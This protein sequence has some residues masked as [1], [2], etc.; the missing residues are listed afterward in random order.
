MLRHKRHLAGVMRPY[1]KKGRDATMAYAH[2]TNLYR[3]TRILELRHVFALEKIHGTSAHIR[4]RPG[5]H[6]DGARGS[7]TSFFSG[8]EKHSRFVEL[9]DEDDLIPKLNTMGQTDIVVYGEAYGGKQQ[10][11][12]ATYGPDLRFVVFEVKV[13]YGWLS[14]TQ[15]ETCA[16]AL[17][18]EFV[19]YEL[20][21]TDMDTI[22]AHRD[23]SS[24]QAQRNGMGTGHKKEGI[25][26]RPPFEITLSDGSRL[27]AKH[28]RDDFRETK[29]LRVV[30]VEPAVLTNAL[31][32]AEEW[33]T[34]MRF[35]HVMGKLPAAVDM[36]HTAA[37]MRAMLEDV[38]REGKGEI[39][40][41]KAVKKAIGHATLKLWKRYMTHVTDSSQGKLSKES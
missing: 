8:G 29:T 19:H 40:E 16:L 38:L 9:F 31:A 25:V 12:R 28:K 4:W 34:P 13:G 32:V 1:H 20:I 37:V 10:G 27:M 33:V 21:D 3:D 23:A 24:V 17:G 36:T 5:Q 14:V 26:L 35:A 22:N 7:A 15:A 39:E 2:I 11:M 6:A 30:G 18:L 41:T